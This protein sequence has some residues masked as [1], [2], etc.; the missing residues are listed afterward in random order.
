MVLSPI[1]VFYT[2]GYRYNPKKQVIE[3]NGNLILDSTPK[4]AQVFLDDQPTKHTTPVN[5]QDVTPGTHTI[6][7]ELENRISWEKQLDVKAERVTFADHVILWQ[8]NPTAEL[9]APLTKGFFTYTNDKEFF[10]MIKKTTSGTAVELRDANGVILMENESTSTTYENIKNALLA[11]QGSSVAINEKTNTNNVFGLKPKLTILASST[12][13]IYP[14]ED[15]FVSEGRLF[16]LKNKQFENQNLNGFS[17]EKN[18]S[19][20]TSIL[21]DSSFF[22]TRYQLPAG[23]WEIAY[24]Q[25]PYI[26]LHETINQRWLGIQIK[27]TLESRE[28][29]GTQLPEWLAVSDIPQALMINNNELW[30]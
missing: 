23:N 10:G 5:I 8:K 21:K 18:T 6:K 14:F 13:T 24:A 17:L 30:R 27:P 29:H 15:Q 12:Q 11:D 7:L 9:I 1:L 4:G 28:L 16:S 25:R 2:S 26:L 19:T 22:D 3:K 20:E